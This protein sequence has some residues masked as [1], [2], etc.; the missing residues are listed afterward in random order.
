[1]R[2]QM[3]LSHEAR[4]ILEEEK[5]D[6]MK[7]GIS[8]TSGEITD[9]IFEKLEGCLYQIDWLFVK[10]NPNYEGVLAHYTSTNPTTLN[11]N[12]RTINIMEKLRDFLNSQLGMK[13]T[14]YKSFIIRIVLKAYKLNLEEHDIYKK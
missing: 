13:R 12:E 8:K 11:L 5:L 9:E 6:C 10:N 4:V 1:M 14:V 7:L 2:I 3:R